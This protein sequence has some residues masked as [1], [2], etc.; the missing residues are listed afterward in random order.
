MKQETLIIL[1]IRGCE[2][3]LEESG[4]FLCWIP[5][6]KLEDFA[7]AVGYEYL[8]DG[9]NPVNLSEDCICIDLKPI[10]EA[11]EIDRELII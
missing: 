7:K 11:F 10:L 4:E 1:S 3:R 8:S 9:E 2:T 6:Y 5:F